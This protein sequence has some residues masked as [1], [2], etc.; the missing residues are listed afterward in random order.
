MSAIAA[1]I[2]SSDLLGAPHLCHI[3]PPVPPLSVPLEHMTEPP[4]KAG[5]DT[6]AVRR[7]VS[8]LL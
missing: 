3:T 8:M 2:T 4:P 6:L 5:S 7:G 1:I